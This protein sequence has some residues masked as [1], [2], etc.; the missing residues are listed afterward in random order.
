M[1]KKDSLNN[2]IHLVMKGGKVSI[3]YKQSMKNLKNGK[4]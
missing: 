3:G 1:E 2:F 4:I